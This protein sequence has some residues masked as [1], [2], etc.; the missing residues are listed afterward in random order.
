V[1]R[2]GWVGIG[3]GGLGEKRIYFVLTSMLWGDPTIQC[4]FLDYLVNK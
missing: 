1:G 3:V 2:V 4:Y